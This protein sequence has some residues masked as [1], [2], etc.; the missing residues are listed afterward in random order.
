[1]SQPKIKLD[2]PVP[3]INNVESYLQEVSADYHRPRA[4]VRYHRLTDDEWKHNTLEYVADAEDEAWLLQKNAKYTSS[5]TG[6][7]SATTTTTA[8]SNSVGGGMAAATEGRTVAT[9]ASTTTPAPQLT[10]DLLE[11]M[12]DA[13]EKE[14]AFDA[15]I[16]VSQADA[17]FRMKIPQ[18]YH[19]FPSHHH[20]R[21]AAAAAQPHRQ[22]H[23]TAK[24]VLNDVYTV[25]HRRD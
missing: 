6:T 2:I 3:R 23:A 14:T 9:A 25:C 10:I 11:R 20:H 5:S 1:M 7:S 4:Y 8:A 22:G 24:H 15:I 19:I 12:M 21:S 16:T 13:L 17:L 18:F